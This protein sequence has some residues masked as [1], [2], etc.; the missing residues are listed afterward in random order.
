MRERVGRKAPS[1]L[2]FE[3]AQ[4]HTCYPTRTSLA[5]PHTA[6]VHPTHHCHEHIHHPNRCTTQEFDFQNQFF[7]SY[8]KPRRGDHGRPARQLVEVFL[9]QGTGQDRCGP[10]KAPLPRARRRTATL[11]PSRPSICPRLLICSLFPH[12]SS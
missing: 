4:T 11:P 10:V 9:Q 7:T 8:A 5:L 12:P 3:K 2:H 1:K 6:T